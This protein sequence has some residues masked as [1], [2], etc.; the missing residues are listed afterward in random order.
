MSVTAIKDFLGIEPI[1]EGVVNP[2]SVFP[3]FLQSKSL[4]YE[5]TVDIGEKV[6]SVSA[7]PEL[8]FGY[9]SLFEIH[10]EFDRIQ[11][12]LEPE[13]YGDQKIL[14]CRKD[15]PEEKNFK[16]LMIMK[17]DDGELSIWPSYVRLKARGKNN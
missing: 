12:E 10:V 2:E 3:F 6:V 1:T 16:T 14:V 9:N 17:W 13:F 5:L 7:H 4:R 11:I 15:Y 8:P